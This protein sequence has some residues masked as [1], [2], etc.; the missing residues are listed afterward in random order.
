MPN[1]RAG[2][3]RV[4]R[5]R[6]QIA[7]DV[8]FCCCRRFAFC[9]SRE[10]TKT[11]KWRRSR[12]DFRQFRRRAKTI[13]A[14]HET[15]RPTCVCVSPKID[16]RRPFP[17]R[18][19]LFAASASPTLTWAQIETVARRAQTELVARKTG[20]CWSLCL[21]FCLCGGCRANNRARR[22]LS[23]F[24]ATSHLRKRLVMSW[25]AKPSVLGSS[26]ARRLSANLA[27]LVRLFA[28]LPL[29]RRRHN[30][31]CVA[32]RF[33]YLNRSESLSA[34]IDTL[35]DWAGRPSCR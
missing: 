21:S 23:P 2:R 14:R 30:V 20:G 24:I 17:A 16:C 19:C 26:C 33:N 35:R 28:R 29:R 3:A 4:R 31:D 6:T 7:R 22:R 32:R 10:D 27:A 25:K 15:S 18:R 34:T 13:L 12:N 11:R 8:R 5:L 9:Q 1:N